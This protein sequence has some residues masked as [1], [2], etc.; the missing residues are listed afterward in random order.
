ML[1]NELEIA[2]ANA[3]VVNATCD[4]LPEDAL[5]S[6]ASSDL[7]GELDSMEI[8]KLNRIFKSTLRLLGM[9]SVIM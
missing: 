4:I 7:T 5:A 1:R 6:K 3:A 2:G 9:K 8:Q